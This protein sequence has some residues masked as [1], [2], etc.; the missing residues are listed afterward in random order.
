MKRIL[1][2]GASGMLG[3][4]LYRFFIN[5]PHYKTFGTIR[6]HSSSK[7]FKTNLQNSLIS[8][9]SLEEDKDIKTAFNIANPDIVINCVGIIKQ[10]PNA[11]DIHANI[12]INAALPHKLSKY[13]DIHGARLIHFSTDCVFTGKNGYYKEEDEADSRDLYGVTKLL[14]EVS[15]K[16]TL[17]LRTSIIGHELNSSK[18]LIDWFLSQNDAIKGYKNAI[19]SGLPTI[20]IASVLKEYVIPN[21]KLFGLYHL[22]VNPINKYDLLSMVSQRYS[23]EIDIIPD[24]SIK[25]DRSLNSDRFQIES[26]FKPKTWQNLI[27]SMYKDY[28]SI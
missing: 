20:E 1:I 10:Q 22:S 27:D 5:D 19:F 18:S 4:T 17:T 9:I 26:G 13:C 12:I 28:I 8:N 15:Y 6:N 14:G 25:I 7:Y 11:N 16:N 2:L 24:E 23:K 3:S 21:P